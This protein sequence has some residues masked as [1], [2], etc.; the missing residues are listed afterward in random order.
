MLEFDPKSHKDQD[1]KSHR[2]RSR[3]RSRSRDRKRRRHSRSRSRGRH[4]RSH[5]KDH[6]SHRHHRSSNSRWESRRDREDS[7]ALPPF[8]LEIG[9]IFEGKVT[10]IV[11]FGCFVQL[12]GL[13]KRREGLVYISQLRREGKVTSVSDV[14]QR[15]QRVKVKVLSINGQKTSLSMKDVDQDSGEDLN[16][17]LSSTARK[18]LSSLISAPD[19]DN[20]SSRRRVQTLSSSWDITQMHRGGQMSSSEVTRLLPKEDDDLEIELVEEEP[21][22]MKGG[23]NSDLS[24]I[25]IVKHLK[26]TCQFLIPMA[27]WRRHGCDLGQ[28]VGYSI[29]FDDNTSPETVIKYMTDDILL[30]ECLID[31]DLN[32]YTVVILD[33]AHERTI[34]TD[35]LFG[36]LKQAVT[37]RQ[38]KLKL[39]V[40]STTL[41]SI[42]FSEYF[43]KAAIFTICG[44]M[45]P[46]EVLYSKEPQ[47]DYLDASVRTVM[48][49]HR[50]ERPGDILLFL[51]GREEIDAACEILY[52]ITMKSRPN[53]SELII[54]PVYSAQPSEM[55]TW[56]FEPA[57]PGSRKN[58]HGLLAHTAMMQSALAMERQ[59]KLAA[60]MCPTE[61]E[62]QGIPEWKKVKMGGSKTSYGKKKEM[63]IVQQRQNLPIYQQK[64]ELVKAV[65][66]NPILV[67]IG[68]TGSGKTTQITQYLAKAKSF[69]TRGKVI[70]CTLP[71]RVAAMSVAKRVAE[72]YGCDLGQEVG[73]SI[74]FDDN[75][76]PETVIKYMTDDILL[77]ECLIDPDLNGY[78]V[79][80]LDEAHERT[81]HTDVLFG[82]LKQ[83]VTRRQGKL[84]LIVTS[85][86]LDS[87]KFSEYFSKAAIFTICGR[88]FP[89]EVLYSKEPQTDYLDA[90]VRTVMEIHREE[91]PGDILLFLTGR[92]EIDAACEIL[93][94]ITMKSRP[95]VSELIIL[96]V[97]SAQP[98]EMQTWIFEPASPGSRKVFIATNIAEMIDGIH[99]VIDTGFM[100]Q[101]VYNT[102][103]GMDS[104]DVV[105]ISQ[106]CKQF[107]H[108]LDVVSCGENTD[109]VQ[110]AICSGFFSNAAKKDPQGGYR[111]LVDDQ[112]VYI[113]P[114][115]ALF[116]RQPEWVLYH[117]IVQT[118]KKYMREVTPI[119]SNWLVEFAPAFF[120][121]QNLPLYNNLLTL[122]KFVLEEIKEL[123]HMTIYYAIF[124]TYMYMYICICIYPLAPLIYYEANMRLV[125]QICNS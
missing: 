114:S 63:P 22:F 76:S 97:Y 110:K 84:K 96:P 109:Q 106:V 15:G 69:A 27:Y 125:Y 59:K 50:E 86:T 64:A 39:I 48:E 41:D 16:P 34:H 82:L 5:T 68:E 38:G 73:Y 31:P 23:S 40:T 18:Q 53:V 81:I 66:E 113:H 26:S 72:E 12:E 24:P 119:H 70:G 60:N 75:T 37:R 11:Q 100:K 71:R 45:F 116:S 120:K 42:K 7:S 77:S 13:E 51:T 25:R 9:K 10:N 8:E 118:T 43:S 20:V 32:G 79:V 52:D 107:T 58:P 61:L 88:M 93:Y 56:I 101:K 3:S 87:I 62:V 121:Y 65:T 14:V 92:E 49:I 111:T 54:L 124:K 112:V 117:K 19:A 28:E 90:S 57:S 46:V 94:D 4:S 108:K 67:V 74:R 44:R 80:M 122:Q 47:T 104:F 103:T 78:T 95:N 21:P 99:Y 6:K 105:P 115:S 29:R 91:R 30:S 55:Q 123:F 85:T 33:E 83:A 17:V 35:V 89:V 1:R 102:K 2:N 36:L 98:S